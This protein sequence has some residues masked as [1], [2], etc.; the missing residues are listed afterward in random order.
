ML[1]DN[2]L[3]AGGD[4]VR[5]LVARASKGADLGTEEWETG[6]QNA[7]KT[8]TL[9]RDLLKAGREWGGSHAL[10]HSDDGHRYGTRRGTKK[11]QKRVKS[12]TYFSGLKRFKSTFLPKW[13]SGL[14]ECERIRIS[15]ALFAMQEAPTRSVANLTA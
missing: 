10:V 7:D 14:A 11:N 3:E 4:R 8:L 2:L 9:R 13:S 6:D 1:A 12:K 15:P 5:S